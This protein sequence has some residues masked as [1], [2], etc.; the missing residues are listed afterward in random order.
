[1]ASYS[2]SPGATLDIPLA[3]WGWGIGDK[4][5][6]STFQQPGS[7]RLSRLL[8]LVETGRIDPTIFMTRT[9]DFTDVHAALDDLAARPPGHVKPLILL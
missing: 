1:M 6:L 9:Y 7:E 4:T 8:R 3:A 5:I 2:G